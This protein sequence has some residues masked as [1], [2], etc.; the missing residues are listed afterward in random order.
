LIHEQAKGTGGKET[1]K[2]I[3][4]NFLAKRIGKEQAKN[5][6]EAGRNNTAR[7]WTAN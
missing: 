6:Q 2:V 1:T 3:H 4:E 7:R 5:R